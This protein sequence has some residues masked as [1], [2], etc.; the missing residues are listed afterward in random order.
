MIAYARRA[1]AILFNVLRHRKDPRPFL[2]PSNVCP[3][4]P[5]TFRKAGQ[6]YRF[7]DIESQG[8][9]LDRE[10]CIRQIEAQ[11]VGLAGV[12]YVRPYGALEDISEFYRSARSRGR[13]LLI[14]D[15]RCL[16]D[17][18]PDGTGVGSEADV[19]LYSTGMAKPVDVGRGGFAHLGPHLGYSEGRLEFEAEAAETVE[20]EYKTAV[21][22]CR[23]FEG[24]GGRWL[25]TRPPDS[26]WE[27]YREEVLR[28]RPGAAAHRHCLNRVYSEALPNSIQLPPRFHGWRFQ[29]RVPEPKALIDRLEANG[30]FAS[31]HY[32]SLGRGIFGPGVFPKAEALAASVVNLFN[33][34][35]Y[36]RDR[37][38]RTVDVVIEHLRQQRGSGWRR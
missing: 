11:T 13:N 18:D 2:L 16:C 12:L 22:E 23:P 1:S 7:V 3:I 36:D 21:R 20:Q 4:V 34:R 9:G 29:I 24:S 35:H 31:R 14:I 5:I 17:P 32:A 30:L 19:T 26:S 8:L 15:D 33:D 28:V 27:Q 10:E 6:P 25:D 37:A 38:E